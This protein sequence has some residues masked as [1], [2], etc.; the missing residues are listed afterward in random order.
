VL[1]NAGKVAGIC[2]KASAIFLPCGIGVN[3]AH[4]RRVPNQVERGLAPV[5]VV[6]ETGKVPVPPEVFS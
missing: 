5:S 1:L 2:L 6:A 3:L 4:A